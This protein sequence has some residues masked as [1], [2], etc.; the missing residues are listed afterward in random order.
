MAAVTRTER[1]WAGHFICGQR[2]SFRRNTLLQFGDIEI[3]VSTVGS[4]PKFDGKP[5]LE[6]IGL[7]RYYETMAFHSDT[8]DK[9]YHDADVSREVNF[10]SPWAISAVDADDLANVMHEKVVDEIAQMMADGLVTP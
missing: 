8:N 7:N 2:C 10:Q 4:L 6:E 5:G 3:I 9:R 1:G